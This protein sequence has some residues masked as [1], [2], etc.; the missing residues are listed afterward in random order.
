MA[1]HE[2]V[3]CPNCRQ[4]LRVP[5]SLG[6]L[7]V[8][9]PACGERFQWKAGTRPRR[10]WLAWGVVA[11]VVMGLLVFVA[12]LSQDSGESVN[13]SSRSQGTHQPT[14]QHA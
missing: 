14:T 2:V 9:C 7:S 8:T 1:E 12:S 13:T 5:M 4:G 6:S 10:P 3:I 11:A